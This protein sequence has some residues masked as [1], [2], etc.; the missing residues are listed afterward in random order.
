MNFIVSSGILA[1][2]LQSISG[3]LSTSNTLPI[4]DNFLFDIDNNEL[5]VSA[6][7]LETTMRTKLNVEANESG[8][9]CIP[10]KMLLDI[11]K[12]L[13]EQPCT[14]IVNPTDHSIELSYDNGKSKMPGFNGN[15]YPKIPEFKKSN[16]L[17][18]TGEI[19]SKAINK[20]IFATGNDDLRPIMSGVYCQFSPEE[21]IFVATDAHKLVC[22]KRKDS[23]AEGSASFIL[24][25]KPL[26][27]LKSNLKGDEEVLLEF[28]DSNAVFTFNDTELVC[29]LIDGKYPNYEA[30]I[31]AE[32]PN[33]LTVD[34]LQFLGALK[35]V[36]IFSN[37]STHQVK[38]S[39][40][41]QELALFAEDLDFANQS[42][43]RLTCSYDG[44]DIEIAFNSKFL[45][46]ML[47]N[48]DS[49]EI[50]IKMSAPNRAGILVPIQT[51][52]DNEHEDILMLVMP[53]MLHR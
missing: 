31:P 23:I 14:F 21:L 3:V 1:K 5:T 47:S 43:E 35:R 38:I 20:T 28:N 29:R 36:S 40:N 6:S 26:N 2:H 48:L 33:E 45:M 17:K 42:S 34:R 49:R 16:Q 37:K 19:I 41:G 13:P 32:N 46:E 51:E 52:T 27:I 10:A 22:Y 9:I 12:N 53:V 11:L 18:V 39:I 44:D 7:D 15:E 25:K 30:V 24:P 8:K 50:K 4:L